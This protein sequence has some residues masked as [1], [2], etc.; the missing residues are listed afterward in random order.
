MHKNVT[1]LM[2]MYNEAATIGKICPKVLALP[3][4]QELIIVDDASTDDSHRLVEALQ[5][6]RIKLY[7]HD[8]NRGKTAALA[9]GL[10]QVAGDI[11]VIQDADLEY[12]PDEIEHL[13]DP[14]W[15]GVA[16]VVYGS[17]FLVRRASRVLYFYHYLGNRFITFFSNLFTNKNMSDVETCYKAFRS[18]LV[19]DLP[20]TSARFGFEVEVTAKISKTGARIYETPIS[21]HGRT[22]EQG[23]KITY[24]DGIM[25]LWYILKYNLITDEQTQNYVKRTNAALKQT[26]Q[27]S[28]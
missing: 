5:D 15:D 18:D 20:I 26:E 24:R 16:D 21:Y 7:R 22:Y 19:K 2:P 23:K 11:V 14:I 9:T 1:I 10:R 27:D 8:R 12:D 13:C 25:A 6:K 28:T 4:V 17:R 3:F